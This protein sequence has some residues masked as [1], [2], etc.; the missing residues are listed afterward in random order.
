MTYLVAF[1]YNRWILP[2][3]F[4][5]IAILPYFTANHG[6]R[7]PFLEHISEWQLLLID[8]FAFVFSAFIW[9]S[10]KHARNYQQEL[11]LYKELLE[12]VPTDIAVFDESH[13]YVYLNREAISDP[14]LRSF[15]V[16]KTDL[17][18][19]E[20]R[21]YDL[22]VAKERMAKFKAAL[23]SKQPVSWVDS[24]YS[25]KL[26]LRHIQRT[27]VPIYDE[28]GNFYR[29]FGFGA[30]VTEL[31]SL[32][33]K[34]ADLAANMRYANMIQ[35]F[36]MPDVD[37]MASALG[38]AFVIWKPKDTVSGD[39]YWFRTVGND[40]FLAVADCTGHGVAGALLTVICMDALNRCL[41]EFHLNEPKQILEKCQELLSRS[42]GNGRYSGMKDGMDICLCRF[43]GDML[44]FSS[45]SVP[46]YYCHDHVVTVFKPQ[47]F[48]IG[49]EPNKFEFDQATVQLCPGDS[50]Y[51]A[52]DGILDQF[53]GQED[54]KFGQRKLLSE[55]GHIS[56]HPFVDQDKLFLQSFE[57][58]KGAR[59]QL[60][61]K[62]FLGIL[63]EGSD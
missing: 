57:G 19:F 24:L 60:D 14:E 3:F 37:Q 53:G 54:R 8:F 30:N 34:G 39:F 52:T 15:I 31:N 9:Y 51:I 44:S 17:E 56:Y 49:S 7:Q 23:D 62:T 43:S 32:R 50:I 45:A 48:S 46:L 5:V 16:G 13:R 1:S 4:P 42:W 58:W 38:K 47:R 63:F 12:S 35:R 21:G 28:Q 36:L 25:K 18:Y 26:G 29:M 41:D 27:F 2:L 40:R 59:E 22:S 11:L 61:D 33:S 6:Q 10:D 55:I 20:H